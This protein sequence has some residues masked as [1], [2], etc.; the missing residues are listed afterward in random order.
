MSIKGIKA[1]IIGG[2]KELLFCVLCLICSSKAE[3][4]SAACGALYLCDIFCGSVYVT[5]RKR[6]K[7]N[8]SVTDCA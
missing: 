4:S 8:L 2:F 3:L 6:G 5:V 1:E 7:G